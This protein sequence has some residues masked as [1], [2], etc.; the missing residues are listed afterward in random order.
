MANAVY[1]IT[2]KTMLDALIALGTLK[3]A[4]VDTG[5]YTYN[6]AHDFYNDVSAGVVGTPVALTGV[7]TTGGALNSSAFTFT[8]VSGAS[9]EAILI[10]VD[11]GNVAT[12]P[13]LAYVDTGQTNL[14]VT[15]NGGNI[16]FTPTT[17]IFQL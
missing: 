10:Y 17:N 1:P 14:P 16:T 3:A 8:S 11:T 7:T 5:T 15:P 12:S 4:L 6:A 13:I 9:C 2:K